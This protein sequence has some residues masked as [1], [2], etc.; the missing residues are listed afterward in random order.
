MSR[1]FL[2]QKTNNSFTQWYYKQKWK[3]DAYTENSGIGS[4]SVKDFNFVERSYYG[5]VDHENNPVVPN[6]EFMVQLK[7]GRVL[8]FVADSV[9]LMRLN[10][11]SAVRIGS[12]SPS[13]SFLNELGIISSYENPRIR[14]GEYLRNILQFYNETHIPISLGKH[15]ITSYDDYVNN[16]FKFF[17]KEGKNIPLTMSKWLISKH[18]SVFETGLAF[19]F[20]DIPPD[21][22]QRKVDEIIDSDS[23][24]YF[25]N[26][27]LNMGFSISHQNP[28]VLVY[29]LASPAT[30]SIRNKY[31]LFNLD[32][33]FKDRFIKACTLD[34]QL[35]NNN[36]NIYY[37]KYVENNSLVRVVKTEKCKTVSEYIQL[38]KV[39]I[40][41]RAMSDHQ[42]LEFYIKVRNTE[43][44]MPYSNEDVKKIYKRA[45][46]LLKRLDKTQSIGYINNRFKDELWNKDYGYHDLVKKLKGDTK[47]E[48]QRSQVGGSSISSGGSGGGYSGGSSGGGGSS[49]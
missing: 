43:E 40:N 25:K 31:S 18:A 33:V 30:A 6:D 41:K 19:S 13:D 10:Y 24:E 5:L 35:L 21:E 20:T 49:Y 12:I 1:L 4:E 29:D 47:T 23:F 27:T 9:S 45:K 22:D 17:L 7:D 44:G 28:N 42:E 34:L 14:Y 37:N 3:S 46:I 15:S 16:F 32:K 8:D 2:Q 48:T 26:L 39:A 36:I 11:L 38:S